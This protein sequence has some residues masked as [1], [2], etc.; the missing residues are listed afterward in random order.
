MVTPV[1]C[2]IY[3]VKKRAPTRLAWE[4]FV[5]P[6]PPGLQL[7]HRCDNSLCFNPDHL[8]AGTQQQNQQDR[9]AAERGRPDLRA[10]PPPDGWAA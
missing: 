5:G 10:V 7:N 3:P 4:T 1:G 6:V 8:Y 2:W 9:F